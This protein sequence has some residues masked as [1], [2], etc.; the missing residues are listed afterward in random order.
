VRKVGVA[1]R[2]KRAHAGIG[3]ILFIALQQFSW[4]SAARPYR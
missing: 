2:R 1:K 4:H 3:A